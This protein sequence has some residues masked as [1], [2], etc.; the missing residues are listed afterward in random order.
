LAAA[1]EAANDRR[2]SPD[3][4][5]KK[6][7]L[8]AAFLKR[9]VEVLAVQPLRRAEPPKTVPALPLHLLEEKNPADARRPAVNGW[10][11]KGPALPVLVTNSS[12]R[13][14]H[15]PGRLSAHGVAVHP[16]PTEFVA[17]AWKSPLA[18]SVRVAVR[19]TH[20]HPACGNGVA[21]WLEHRRAGR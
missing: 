7:G 19:V 1:V 9:W 21:W 2:T 17:V 12:G 8:D 18:G 6:H 11:K 5:A 10:R 20:A 13:V 14:E 3:D 15:I 4:L 16:T